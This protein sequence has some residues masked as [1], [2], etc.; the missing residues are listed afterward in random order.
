M[1]RNSPELVIIPLAFLVLI[2]MLFGLMRISGQNRG[3]T[4]PTQNSG[5]QANE[6]AV[7]QNQETQSS[8]QASGSFR[9]IPDSELVYGPVH[10][11]WRVEDVI[12]AESYLG[13]YTESVEGVVLNGP[14]IIQLVAD[15]TRVSPRI[16]IAMLEFRGGWIRKANIADD[17]YAMGYR[18]ATA[19][20]LYSQMI[21]AANQANRGYY[22]NTEAG[23]TTISLAD[24]TAIDVGSGVNPGTL[25]ILAWLGAQPGTNEATWRSEAQSSGFLNTFVELFG[26][27]Y[28][29]ENY[30]DDKPTSQPDLALPWSSDET[31]YFTGGPHGGWA[32]GSAWAALDF[33]PPENQF[34]CYTSNSWVTA[35]ADGVVTRSGFGAVELDTDGDGYSGTGWTIL[36]QHIDTRDRLAVGAQVKVGDRI[37]HPSCEGG[38][39]S[40]THLHIARLYNGRWVSAD[41]TP[42]FDLGGWQ[43]SGSG[44]EYNGSLVRNGVNK[45]AEVGRFESNAISANP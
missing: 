22:G 4:A 1:N 3:T 9:I 34:G 13:K 2:L 18:S 27:P 21:W 10:E 26:D 24:G 44:A 45:T 43:A 8:T 12:S 41:Q 31:W 32:S 39:S 7:S 11:G 25:G 20:G 19:S 29:W 38:F 14:E 42:N 37:G 6:P 16:L 28:S 36:Y 5:V 15:R 35:V 30:A 33:V 17:G 23:I 40:G